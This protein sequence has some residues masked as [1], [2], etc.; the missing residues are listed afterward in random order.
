[1]EWANFGTC[2]HLALVTLSHV[3][4]TWQI[5]FMLC[6]RPVCVYACLFLILSSFDVVYIPHFAF[7]YVYFYRS[8]CIAFA[9]IARHVLYFRGSYFLLL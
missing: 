7:F 5:F 1:M 8:M 4:E 2:E 6:C 9:F 3:N